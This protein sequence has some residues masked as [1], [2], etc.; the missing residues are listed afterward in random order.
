MRQRSVITEVGAMQDQF[1]KE[2]DDV[3]AH[4]IIGVEMLDDG[5][6][7]AILNS[8]KT[9]GYVGLGAIT[10]LR[11]MLDKMEKNMLDGYQE[12]MDDH[13]ASPSE[14][15]EF[16]DL[17]ADPEVKELIMKYSIEIKEAINNEDE[18]A[19][20]VL[21]EKITKELKE[22]KGIDF[23]ATLIFGRR[24]KGK[25]KNDSFNINDISKMK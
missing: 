21:K 2:G 15:K 7:A 8:V 19:L 12:M 11:V 18:E 25:G 22:V 1:K 23:D 20:S 4:I 24:G 6:P 16:H 5:R 13:H 14:A 9:G 3:F 17:M 10:T